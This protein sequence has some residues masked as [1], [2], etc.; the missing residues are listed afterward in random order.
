MRYIISVFLSLL[1]MVSLGSALLTTASVQAQSD[2]LQ[3]IGADSVAGTWDDTCVST[4]PAPQGGGERF[5]R[6]YTFTLQSEAA[7][8][9]SLSSDED[10]FMYVLDGHGVSGTIVFENDDQDLDGGITD[11]FI[12]ETFQ[13]GDYTIEATT[14]DAQTTGTFSLV[15][16]GLP[17]PVDTPE[18]TDTPP[19]A[20]DTPESTPEPVTPEPSPTTIPTVT[21]EPPEEP[22]SSRFVGASHHA[23]ALFRNGTIDCW[24][25]DE[26]GEVSGH[27]SSGGHITLTLGVKHSCALDVNGR[28]DC[29]G[30]NDKGQ[31][32]PPSGDSYVALVSGENYTCAMRSDE[33]VRCWGSFKRQP[34]ATPTLVP[35]TPVPTVIPPPTATPSPDR[36]SEVRGGADLSNCDLSNRNFFGFRLAGANFTGANLSGTILVE[37]R[38]TNAILVRANLT[39]ADL[40]GANLNSADLTDTSLNGANFNDASLRRVNLSGADMTD[41]SIVRANL[42]SSDLSGVSLSNTNFTEAY[43]GGAELPGC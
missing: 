41:A 36:C 14:Y 39:G 15:L 3:A 8:T 32:S 13:P 12:G 4:R 29:W 16:T 27:P 10:T 28:I 7:L 1:A 24:G 19:T 34:E 21:P 23:C 6:Y 43:L 18:P 17:A 20:T 5:A 37:A 2:C 40:R 42:D 33:V 9:I 38:L 31:S 35:P 22:A 11:S 26:N 30:A 25:D